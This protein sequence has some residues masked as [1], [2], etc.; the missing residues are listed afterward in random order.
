MLTVHKVRSFVES[1]QSFIEK[2]TV[3]RKF[4]EEGH[5]KIV[6]V[7]DVLDLSDPDLCHKILP[8]PDEYTYEN[9][10]KSGVPLQEVP[11]KVLGYSEESLSNAL[12]ALHDAD[13]A[14]AAAQSQQSD[15]NNN[16]E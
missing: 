3:Q 14:A 9:L 11:S 6:I 8:N 5:D 16:V 4:V 7:P 13:A 2:T 15:D 10:V 1:G 12:R